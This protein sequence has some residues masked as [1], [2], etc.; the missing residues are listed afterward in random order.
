MVLTMAEQAD[1]YLVSEQTR[2]EVWAKVHSTEYAERYYQYLG[3]RYMKRHRVCTYFTIGLGGGAV[4]PL[5]LVGFS[6]SSTALV[7]WVLGIVGVLLAGVTIYNLVGDFARR[8]SVATFVARTCGRA[9]REFRD[10]LNTI[11]LNAIDE[12]PARV[13]LTRLATLVEHE[14]YNTEAF[15]IEVDN[16]DEDSKRADNETRAHLE[17]LYA[18]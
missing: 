3:N 4:V 17:S 10:L 9:A 15:G 18:T 7:S 2:K 14:T 13:E 5:I 16:K 12:G 1:A 11:D 8:A 6:S